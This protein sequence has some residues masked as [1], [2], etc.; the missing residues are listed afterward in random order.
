VGL[1]TT[2]WPPWKY[3]WRPLLK[4]TRS[5][6]SVI[7][8]LVPR[9][10]VW[11]TLTARVPCSNAANIGER[12]TWTKSEFCIWQNSDTEQETPKVYISCISPGDDQTSCKVWLT[13][14][15]RRRCSNETKIHNPLKFAGVPQTHQRISAVSG[16]KFVIFWRHVDEILLSNFFPMLYICLSCEDRL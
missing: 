7:S 12:K 2:W 10:K 1:C 15:E 8:F 11:L 4:I 5:E 16:P 14:V 9:R 13:S 6:S 3:W